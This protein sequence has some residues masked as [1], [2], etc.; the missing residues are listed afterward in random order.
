MRRLFADRLAIATVVV[1]ILLALL[2][3][4]LRVS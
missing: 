2:F 1:V 3:A 4:Y